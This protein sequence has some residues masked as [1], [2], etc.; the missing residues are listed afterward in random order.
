M[1]FRQ[2][3]LNFVPGSNHLYSNSGYTLAAEIVSRVSGKPFPQ[4]CAERIFKPLGMTHTLFHLDLHQVVKN[5]AYSYQG[6][7]GA[8]EYAPLNY[9]NAGAT[10]L[11]T[12]A[13]D[14]TK[15]LDNFRDPKVGGNAGIARLQE[16]AVL[17]SGKTIDYALGVSVGKNRGLKT[18]SH[19]GADAG[20]RSYVCWYPEQN[21]GVAVVNNLGSFDTGGIADKVAKIYLGSK[22]TPDAPAVKRSYVPMDAAVLKNYEGS[23]PLPKI[24]QT[25]V[26]VVDG[27]KLM[28]AGPIRPPLELK[29]VSASHFYVE[30]LSAD[31]EFAPE[32]NGGMKVKVTQPGPVV[33]EGVRQADG[34]KVAPDFT[35]YIGTYWSEELE[36]EYSFAVKNGK[37]VATQAH[38]GVVELVAKSG[39]EFGSGEWF[40]PELRFVRGKDGK[41]E[42]VVIGGGR[43]KGIRFVRK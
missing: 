20:Y 33:N 5:R 38:H 32:A 9:A 41:V 2:K 22:M 31:V 28:A 4:F 25:L 21:F 12:T 3:E 36:T 14:L 8:Y 34:P 29:P 19:G 15:W 30:E 27:G 24:G 18:I 13:T 43:V 39:D 42:A 6:E 17:T 40:M 7:A 11:F 1:L 16:Q 35:P 23:Y 37:L 10:S 26:A